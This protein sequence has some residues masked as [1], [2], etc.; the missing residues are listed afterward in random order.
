MRHA[1]NPFN[2]FN[3]F[4]ST[5]ASILSSFNALPFNLCLQ[6]LNRFKPTIIQRVPLRHFVSF[7]EKDKWVFQLINIRPELRYA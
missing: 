3:P 2:P 7:R 4:P 5:S 6:S 1:F